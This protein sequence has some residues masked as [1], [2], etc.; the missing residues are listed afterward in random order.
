MLVAKISMKTFCQAIA[1]ST[2]TACRRRVIPGSKYCLYH[3]EYLP[4]IYAALVGALLG[5]AINESY[6]AIIPSQESKLVDSLRKQIT[7]YQKVIEKDANDSK[8]RDQFHSAQLDTLNTR[9]KPFEL[10]AKKKY[11][12]YGT[13]KALDLLRADIADIREMATPPTISY[14][15]LV[16]NRSGNTVS[17]QIFFHKS[18]EGS[19]EQLNF[20][21][22][23]LSPSSARIIDIMPGCTAFNVSTEI[24]RDRKNAKISFS[25]SLGVEPAISINISEYSRIEL[26]SKDGSIN[27]IIDVK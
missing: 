17:A 12:M 6:K 5:L 23:I 14:K 7:V 16:V 1:K 24:S 2:G 10:I 21:L 9:L 18:K 26:Q 15:N 11:P 22:K 8:L 27:K 25:P 13:E 20:D 4:L 3:I 19:I